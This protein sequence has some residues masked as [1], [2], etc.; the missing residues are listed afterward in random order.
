VKAS[1]SGNKLV[2]D[3]VEGPIIANVTYEGNKLIP[4]EALTE[5]LKRIGIVEGNVLK[6]ATVEQVQNE[7][8][9]QYNQQGYYNSCL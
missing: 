9:Q 3:V 6:Q 2:F 5:G 7:L 1:Q 8:K 4:K